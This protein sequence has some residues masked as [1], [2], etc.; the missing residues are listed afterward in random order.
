M[1]E[2]VA[3]EIDSQV[4]RRLQRKRAEVSVEIK[5]TE[6]LLMGLRADLDALDGTLAILDPARAVHRLRKRPEKARHEAYKGEM[7]QIV[8]QALNEA[9]N[10]LSTLDV[11][12]VVMTERALDRAD[13]ALVRS[14]RRRA[15]ACLQ[16]LRDHKLVTSR[17]LAPKLMV[18]W[19]RSRADLAQASS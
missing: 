9:M 17:L 4:F 10:P 1:T 12:N 8:L 6:T 3:T 18:W 14:V 11:A 5:E 2:V 7:Q 19:L 16:H 13:R 15:L